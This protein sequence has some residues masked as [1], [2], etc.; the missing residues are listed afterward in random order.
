M[1]ATELDG[2]MIFS[3][4]FLYSHTIGGFLKSI[5]A[6]VCIVADYVIVF[7]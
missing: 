1:V 7:Q 6:F 5:E 2:S 4:Y 3:S